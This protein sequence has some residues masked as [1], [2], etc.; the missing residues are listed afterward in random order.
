MTIEDM[1][2]E[3][4]SVQKSI[5]TDTCK[6]FDKTRVSSL[7]RLSKRYR[8]MALLILIVIGAN[9]FTLI[10]YFPVW[11]MVGFVLLLLV[12]SSFSFYLEHRISSIDLTRM[13]VREVLLRVKNCRK[14]HLTI[15]AF[16]VPCALF[17][18]LSLAYVNRYDAYFLSAV[19]AG[20]IIGIPIGISLLLRFLRDYRE[21]LAD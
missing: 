4:Q 3:W 14:M 13:P 7:Q 6:E 10:R 21:A 16:G 12:D 18:C 15:V 17:L 2:P 11:Y 1:K 19:M 8:R 5:N 20:S 9:W